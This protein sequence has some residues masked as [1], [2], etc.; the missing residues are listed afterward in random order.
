MAVQVQITGYSQIK[1]QVAD[2][3]LLSLGEV[4]DMV[5]IEE[6]P[7]YYDVYGDRH[8]GPQGPPI[9]TQYLGEVHVITMELSQWDATTLDILR[10]R[11]A[12][13]TLGR[14]TLAEVGSLTFQN[15]HTRLIIDSTSRPRNYPLTFNREPSRF[16]A[17]SKYT[18]VFLQFEAHVTR[19]GLRDTILYDTNT[20][21]YATM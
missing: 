13:A 9:D 16:G 18:G 1:I 6:R 20:T 8:G 19:G 7:F 2:N 12:Q 11:R 10:Q 15:R 21:V 14:V 5:E 17:G 3:T 4:Q